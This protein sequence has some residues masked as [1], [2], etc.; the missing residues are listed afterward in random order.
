M[1]RVSYN[2]HIKEVDSEANKKRGYMWQTYIVK[3]D[4]NTYY[5]GVTNNIKRRIKLHNCGKGAKYTAA[6]RP[7]QLIYSEQFFSRSASQKRE[8]EIKKLSRAKKARLI[9]NESWL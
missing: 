2:L 5:T 1:P 6:R 7:V 9:N 4:D 3:C 8:Y